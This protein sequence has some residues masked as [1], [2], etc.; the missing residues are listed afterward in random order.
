MGSS[1]FLFKAVVAHALSA[2]C[3]FVLSVVS[4]TPF[5]RTQCRRDGPKASVLDGWVQIVRG[6]RPKS[7]KWPSAKKPGKS[8]QQPRDAAASK[9]S[10]LL[11]PRQPSRPPEQVAA[12]ATEE[13]HKLEA[14]VMA[15]GGENSVHAKRLVEVLKTAR[16][17]SRVLPV[18]ERLTS[19]WNFFSRTTRKRVARV[20]DLVAKATEQKATFVVV[21]Q[22]AEER[23]KQ[24]EAEAAQPKPPVTEL[25][26]R[27]DG[28]R[29]RR[30]ACQC[31]HAGSVVWRRSPFQHPADA[32][33]ARLAQRPELRVAQCS[34]VWRHLNH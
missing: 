27:I 8:A 28:A 9:S 23:L 20:A 29:A 16:A 25:Q 33:F 34:G 32:T 7:E 15:L 21:V 10:S 13:V 14:A 31:S 22:E 19:C 24:L 12:G 17:K 3:S 30:I 1:H 26:R 2:V 4:A 18:G 5:V 11:L 6:P